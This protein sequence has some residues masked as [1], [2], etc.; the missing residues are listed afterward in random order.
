MDLSEIQRYVT[1]HRNDSMNQ[2]SIEPCLPELS[3]FMSYWTFTLNNS[4]VCIKRLL[5]LEN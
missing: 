2:N 3:I 1:H 5:H 4:L